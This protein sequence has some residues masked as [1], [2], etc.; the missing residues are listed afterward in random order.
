MRNNL[1]AIFFTVLF[2][3][4]N[5]APAILIAI[6]DTVDISKF[7]GFSENE[8]ENT[9]NESENF[10][11]LIFFIKNCNKSE[12]FLASNN[13]DHTAYRFKNYSKPYLNLVSP[14]PQV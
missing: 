12:Y 13:L 2:V 11:E 8:E 3:V 5:S 1:I 14:P 6:D 10:F 7:Y 9:G 4:V